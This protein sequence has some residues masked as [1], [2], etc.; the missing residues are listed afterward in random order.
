MEFT[1]VCTFDEITSSFSN[2][3]WSARHHYQKESGF[4]SRKPCRHRG[5]FYDLFAKYYILSINIF[6]F[7][8]TIFNLH[9]LSNVMSLIID[10]NL[11]DYFL[12]D[13]RKSKTICVMW[14]YNY[15]GHVKITTIYVM[16]KL[17][18][19]GSCE[20][21]I[22]LVSVINTTIWVMWKLLL[23]RSCENYNFLGHVKTTTIWVMWKLHS[24]G[25]CENYIH[26]GHVKTTSIWVMRNYKFG[27]LFQLRYL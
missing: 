18:I 27:D 7:K 16:R 23:L 3:I 25:S 2:I 11:G 14:N 26:L 8:N 13:F 20:N 1:F 10:W 12:Y 4:I 5:Y 21:H 17:Q 9:W 19:F 22:Y 6:L 15:L 24:F